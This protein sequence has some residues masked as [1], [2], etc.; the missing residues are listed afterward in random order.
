MKKKS[1]VESMLNILL[2]M[3]EEN[4]LLYKDGKSSFEFYLSE[5][6]DLNGRISALKFVLDLN[7]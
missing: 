7:D 1:E 6:A 3:L 5:R 2:A 4:E